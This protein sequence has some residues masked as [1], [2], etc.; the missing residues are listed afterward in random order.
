MLMRNAEPLFYFAFISN[1]KAHRKANSNCPYCLGVTYQASDRLKSID[2][3]L[4]ME[5]QDKAR[6]IL[7]SEYEFLRKLINYE[8]II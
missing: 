4:K 7:K 6:K 1:E 8:G 5:K 2:V 3:A